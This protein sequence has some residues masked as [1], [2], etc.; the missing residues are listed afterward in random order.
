MILAHY[1]AQLVGAG[2]AA[3]A[4]AISERV[5]AQFFEAKTA[6]G[7]RWEGVL[8]AVGGGSAMTLSLTMHHGANP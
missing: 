8:M 2:W 6:S 7:D 1:A 5:A 3:A 4:P